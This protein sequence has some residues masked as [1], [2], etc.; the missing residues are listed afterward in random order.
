MENYKDTS[1]F[2]ND[3]IEDFNLNLFKY[4]LKKSIIW[5]ILLFILCLGGGFLVIRYS[6]RIYEASA[7]LILKKT[8]ETMKVLGVESIL[9]ADDAEIYREIQLLKSSMMIHRVLDSLPLAVSYFN[10]GRTGLV[11]SE[12]YKT[13]PF[14]VSIIKIKNTQILDEVIKLKF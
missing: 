7:S 5:I 8:P 11:S 9:Q 10:K 6:E 4:V 3:A 14:E 12:M 1:D 2:L 13:S